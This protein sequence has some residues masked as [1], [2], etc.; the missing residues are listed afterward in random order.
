M[1]IPGFKGAGDFGTSVSQLPHAED[2]HASRRRLARAGRLS[3][4][5]GSHRCPNPASSARKAGAEH[6]KCGFSF[7]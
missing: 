5:K 3:G 1:T 2:S 7:R 6:F 4:M